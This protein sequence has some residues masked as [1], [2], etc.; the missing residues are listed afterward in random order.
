MIK[1]KLKKNAYDKFISDILCFPVSGITIGVFLKAVIHDNLLFCVHRLS[2]H[3]T[4]L[5]RYTYTPRGV[6]TL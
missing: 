4:T 6:Q 5:N 2:K 3:V 1:R